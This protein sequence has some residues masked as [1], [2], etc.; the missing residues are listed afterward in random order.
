MSAIVNRLLCGCVPSDRSAC[1][2][3]AM[4]M[5]THTVVGEPGH[6]FGSDHVG[7][8]RTVPTSRSL[9]PLLSERLL[10]EVPLC[11]KGSADSVWWIIGQARFAGAGR[12]GQQ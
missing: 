3:G 9:P 5:A 12:M 6:D 2:G 10:L 7:I 1:G 4:Y 8:R 11:T